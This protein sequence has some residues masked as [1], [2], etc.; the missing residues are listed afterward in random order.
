MENGG[1][2]DTLANVGFYILRQF[3]RVRNYLG[4]G[5]VDEV[6]TTGGRG[7]SQAV[8]LSLVSSRSIP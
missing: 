7:V 8:P 1:G 5:V 4:V 6:A 2:Y 3:D